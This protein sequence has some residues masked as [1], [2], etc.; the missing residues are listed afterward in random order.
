LPFEELQRQAHI[1]P[2]ALK[3]GK[4]PDFSRRIRAAIEKP[5]LQ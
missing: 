5:P 2:L 4:A 3:A 1:N